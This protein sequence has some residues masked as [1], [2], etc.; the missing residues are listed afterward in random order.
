MLVLSM[1]IIMTSSFP[2]ALALELDWSG[3]FWS[4][5]NFVANYSMDS[6]SAGAS[7]DSGRMS[8]GVPQG[9]YIPGGGANSSGFQSVFLRLRPKLIV[10]DNIYVK[11]EWWLGDPIY[12]IF[13]NALP[14]SSDQRWYYSSQSRGSSITAQRFWAEFVTD[15]GTVQV[16]RVPLHYGLGVVWNSGENL[17]D[18]Y[19][20]TGDAIRWVARFGSFTFIPSFIVQSAGIS[21]GGNAQIDQAA[22]NSATVFP[23]TFTPGGGTGGVQDYSI[24]FKYENM[25]DELEGGINLMRRFGGSGQDATFRTALPGGLGNGVMNYTVFDLFARKKFSKLTL[26]AEVPITTGSLGSASY[27][28]FGVATEANW[29][30]NEV[31][32]FQLKTGYASGQ[33]NSTSSS[34]SNFQAF[35]FNPN[36]HLGMILFNYQLA[37]FYAPQTMNNPYLNPSYLGSPY[38]NPIVNA[39]YVSLSTQIKPWDKWT[40]RPG[41]V[42]ARAPQSA[43]GSGFY[44]NTIQ[45]RMALNTAGITQGNDLGYEFDLGLSFQWDEYFQFVWDNG[46]LVPGS[47]YAF[48][49]TSTN[50]AGSPVFATSFR[51]GINF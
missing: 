4:E 22:I 24:L 29:K 5:L 26:G 49:N 42:Y 23:G 14:Y 2:D 11:S 48:S 41:F 12:G 27:Q 47:Y 50:N 18:R 36:Y 33:P 51:V 15:L 31:W 19:M 3:Q 30:P 20:S 32:E 13:G 39:A 10:N 45:N 35:Y 38:N 9:Y 6:S 37:N 7:V 40:I 44:H 34:P 25:E 8:N 43:S 17:W 16:G 21:I 1:L 46:V 28:T